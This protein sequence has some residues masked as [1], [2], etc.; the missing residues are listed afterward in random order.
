MKIKLF[1]LLLAV[2][3]LNAFGNL[4]LAWGIQQSATHLRLNPLV[5]VRVMLNPYAALGIALLILWLLTRMA[6]LSRADLSFVLPMTGAG[7]V[8]AAVLGWLFLHEVIT[9]AHWFGVFLIFLGTVVVGSTHAK[10]L[11]QCGDPQ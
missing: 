9:T 11:L 4:S 3:C 8:L 1:L 10:T 7:Y 6:L 5:Y 2:C